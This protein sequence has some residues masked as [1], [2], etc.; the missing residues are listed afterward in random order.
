MEFAF[1]F[2]QDT[3]SHFLE[4]YITKEYRMMCKQMLFQLEFIS[5]PMEKFTH[6]KL[7]YSTD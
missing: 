3:G 1:S 6:Q 2:I 4:P 7:A 5:I